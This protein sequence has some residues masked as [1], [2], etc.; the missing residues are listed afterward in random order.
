MGLPDDPNAV[1]SASDLSVRGVTGVRV[2]DASVIPR[3]P[4]LCPLS[5]RRHCSNVGVRPSVW[6]LGATNVGKV[7]G[8][9]DGVGTCMVCA[10]SIL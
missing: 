9:V 8:G 4:G 1:V 6:C 2:V 7:A 3:I 5:P 10:F